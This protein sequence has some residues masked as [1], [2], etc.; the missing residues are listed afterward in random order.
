VPLSSTNADPGQIQHLLPQL[1]RS[2]A[3]ELAQ[4]SRTLVYDRGE[5]IIG[6]DS[7]TGPCL[8]VSGRVR[9]L[10]KAHDGREATLRTGGPGSMLG[11]TTLFEVERGIVHIDSSI[12]AFERSTVILFDRR[13]LLRLASRHPELAL[14]LSHRLADI[15]NSV[16]DAAGQL[17]FMTVR[18]RL[19]V[20]VL[21]SAATDARGRLVT[22]ATQQQ[23]ANA[24]GSVREVV[25][26]TLHDFRAEGLIAVHRGRVVIADPAGLAAAARL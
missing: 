11:L 21:A 14:E 15:A 2:V 10:I 5:T 7:S 8:V 18:Q 13:H 24:V 25:A 6:P 19:A 3:E 12:V 9:L 26:R 17:A 1:T 16:S 23:L 22:T 4:R 20:H